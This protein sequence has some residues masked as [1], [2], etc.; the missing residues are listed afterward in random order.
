MKMQ[1]F[2]LH[3]LSGQEFKV[4]QNI[5]R[6]IQI[7]EMGDLIVEVLIPTEKVSEVKMG[8]KRET[9]R[10]FFPGYIL[11][12]LALYNDDNSI[13]ERTWHFIQQTTGIIGF[14]GGEKP[15]PLRE[16]E[17]ANILN[18][19]EDK[20]EKVTPKVNFGVGEVVK[21][22]DGPFENFTGEVEEITEKGIKVAVSIFGR[23]A[24]VELEYW[25][26]EKIS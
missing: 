21:I 18:Q 22:N 9:T 5:D 1:W 15:A 14:I 4:K 7:E 6:R 25:Q 2:V 19:I 26:V 8:K 10:K 20:K 17:V 12:K 13:N 23:T 24:P 3:C 11:G 16:S